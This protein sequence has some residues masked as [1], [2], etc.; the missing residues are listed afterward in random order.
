MILV[1]HMDAI[2]EVGLKR[3][4]FVPCFSIHCL[5]IEQNPTKVSASL[6]RSITSDWL[7]PNFLSPSLLCSLMV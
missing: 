2:L 3:R 5:F 4:F 1:L 7:V 6:L